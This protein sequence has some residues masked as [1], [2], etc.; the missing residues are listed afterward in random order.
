MATDTNPYLDHDL[1][2]KGYF[3]WRWAHREERDPS[4]NYRDS[5]IPICQMCGKTFPERICEGL[6]VD[7]CFAPYGHE[8]RRI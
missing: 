4:I 8:F 5:K 6:A 1:A 2:W 3:Y 7:L